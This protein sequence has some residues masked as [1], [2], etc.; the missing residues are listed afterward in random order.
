MKKL[1][2]QINKLGE[3]IPFMII[4]VILF[5]LFIMLVIHEKRK[6]KKKN[7]LGVLRTEHEGHD[8]RNISKSKDELKLERIRKKSLRNSNKSFS[9]TKSFNNK[10]NDFVP[11][12]KQDRNPDAILYLQLKNKKLLKVE[13]GKVISYKKWQENLMRESVK[14]I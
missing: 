12:L 6:E 10:N 3:S 4:I 14:Q 13:D 9:T 11:E 8:S 2:E 1:L 7:N 5:V